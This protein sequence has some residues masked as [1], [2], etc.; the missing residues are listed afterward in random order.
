M[1][2]CHFICFLTLFWSPSSKLQW[3]EW[4][5]ESNEIMKHNPNL[6]R[7][8]ILSLYRIN[9]A[10]SIQLIWWSKRFS[11]QVLSLV[12]EML[13]NRRR[14][15]RVNR[16]VGG[17]VKHCTYWNEEKMH[18]MPISTTTIGHR[19]AL[20]R[21]GQRLAV[22]ARFS[23]KIIFAQQNENCIFE[24]NCVLYALEQFE[25]CAL[26]NSFER[27]GFRESQNHQ[28]PG[29]Y[30]YDLWKGIQYE[31]EYI[32]AIFNMIFS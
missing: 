3:I 32:V 15:K 11:N 17:G 16:G 26:C 23:F 2:R 27:F 6:T 31:N 10:K 30:I 25:R 21:C 14:A 22:W 1:V 24:F 20:F 19:I 29:H 7:S 9:N 8:A 12:I 28:N 18:S 13:K 4:M 5:N